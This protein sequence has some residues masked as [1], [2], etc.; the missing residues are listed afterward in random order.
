[1]YFERLPNAFRTDNITDHGQHMKSQI[2][3][4]ISKN[5]VNYKFRVLILTFFVYT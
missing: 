1:M 2:F 5:P 4:L 3:T